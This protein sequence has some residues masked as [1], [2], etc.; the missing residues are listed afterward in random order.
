MTGDAGTD[1]FDDDD[2]LAEELAQA[3]RSD[4]PGPDG[5]AM[6]IAG[7]DIVMADTIEA[8]LLHD[9]ATDE[10]A[11]V[12]SGPTEVR[13][14]T[15]ALP[16]DEDGDGPADL[17]IEFEVVDGRVIGHVEPPSGGHVHLEQ[18]SNPSRMVSSVAPDEQ[19]SFEFVLR[20]PATFRLRYL[21]EAGRSVATGWLDGPHPLGR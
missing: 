16:G 7:Y 15:Y 1:W 4:A 19:G 11:A 21:D 2:R 3:L 14:L 6:V 12:R 20:S 13:M 10:L 17:E 8:D 18:P 9:S 5:A